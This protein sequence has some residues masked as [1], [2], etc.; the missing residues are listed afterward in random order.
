MRD[1]EEIESSKPSFT[2][3]NPEVFDGVSE[4][5]TNVYGPTAHTCKPI[6]SPSRKD[7]CYNAAEW[8]VWERGVRGMARRG[9][10]C[11]HRFFLQFPTQMG[12]QGGEKGEIDGEL[13][14]GSLA[15][16]GSDGPEL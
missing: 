5:D 7:C 2:K 12:R 9:C 10:V 1:D 16:V 14:G 3:G 8:A 6:L 13:Y 15:R 11:A 4:T